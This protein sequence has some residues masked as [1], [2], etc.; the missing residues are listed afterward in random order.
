M[1]LTELKLLF[2]EL[3][4]KGKVADAIR[5]I[6]RGTV[7]VEEIAETNYFVFYDRYYSEDDYVIDYYSNVLARDEAFWCMGEESYFHESDVV[8]LHEGRNSNTYSRRYCRNNSDLHEYNGEFFDDDALDHY[9]LVFVDGS[10]HILHRDEAYYDDDS[11]EYYSEPQECFVRSYHSGSYHSL[12]FNGK[13]KYKIGYEIE[14]EDES[15]R[16]SIKIDR[17]EDKTDELWRKEKDGSLCDYSGFELISPTFEFDIEKIFEHI[18]GNDILVQHINAETSLN[19]GGH[20]HLSKE[21]LTGNDLFD[22]VKGYTPLF[23]A[24]YHGRVD[25][26]YCKGKKNDDLKSDGEK[27]QAIKIHH[28][29]VEFRIIS[30]VKNVEMLK[31]RSKLLMMII[32]NPTDDIIKAYY[33]VDTKFTKLLKQVYSDERLVE[34]KDRF[35]KYTKQFENLDIIK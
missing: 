10:D 14:K 31:W 30:A 22:K 21:G 6:K 33:N 29:R 20:I 26:N 23:Y 16:N 19:C 35:I 1:T 25:K 12:S 18:E 13:S 34:L 27:Y 2:E 28:D 15:V 9:D 11:E 5:S 3:G 24:L 7:T 17:F 4:S 32:N 8:T